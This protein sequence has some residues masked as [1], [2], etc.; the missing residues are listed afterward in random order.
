MKKIFFPLIII[1]SLSFGIN[2]S[3]DADSKKSIAKDK[4]MS[5]TDSQ[6]KTQTKQRNNDNT[7]STT[8]DLSLYLIDELNYSCT[9]NPK[10]LSSFG[11]GF[12][13]DGMLNITKKEFLEN[14]GQNSLFL[15]DIGM[16]DNLSREYIKCLII[17]GARIA[18]SSINF[19]KYSNRKMSE[20]DFERILSKSVE[21]AKKIT[22][23]KIKLIKK[24]ALKNL[25]KDCRFFNTHENI[26]CGNIS[27]E[28]SST[29]SNY[30]T[31][32]NHSL[33]GDSNSLYGIS[34]NV[35]V[36]ISE[37]ENNEFSSAETEENTMSK[38]KSLSK[39][40]SD[41]KSLSI[42]RLLPKF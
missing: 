21:E 2:L 15:K 8:I 16:N 29:N 30:V 42:D 13:E 31:Y 10:T 1:S 12:Y 25:K 20:S 36:S 22:S 14:A 5:Q 4:T 40:L 34:T 19:S 26:M 32:L 6:T 24:R 28:M 23:L 3:T 33:F 11:L 39:D 41:K 38:T 27:L 18:Q 17:A 9:N 35:V 37:S 7:V